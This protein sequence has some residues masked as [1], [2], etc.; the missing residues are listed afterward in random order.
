VLAVHHKGWAVEVDAMSGLDYT[1]L[2]SAID[3]AQAY[4]KTH[5][6]HRM[7][8]A[9][10]DTSIQFSTT[11]TD[12]EFQTFCISYFDHRGQSDWTWVL[13]LNQLT[14]DP[15]A[16]Y[17]PGYGIAIPQKTIDDKT[18][19]YGGT[20][21]QWMATSFMHEFGHSINIL[22]LEGIWPFWLHERYCSNADCVMSGAGAD[23]TRY[24]EP[25]YCFYHW[26]LRNKK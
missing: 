2:G 22:E 18:T 12:A 13:L 4:Y 9:V 8:Y 20:R 26:C 10:D 17:Y 24:H 1:T 15:V 25:W 6:Y 23:N 19:F 3:V 7:E 5:G 14:G 11:T 21:L 16:A